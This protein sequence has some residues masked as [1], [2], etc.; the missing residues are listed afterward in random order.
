MSSE[1]WGTFDKFSLKETH[2]QPCALEKSFWPQ[3]EGCMMGLQAPRELGGCLGLR[4]REG[5]VER[6]PGGTF[7][8]VNTSCRKE[9]R[10]I[11]RNH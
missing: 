3:S 11:A 5:R 10:Q 8:R 1:L 2:N 7:G 9:E 4:E 6:Y